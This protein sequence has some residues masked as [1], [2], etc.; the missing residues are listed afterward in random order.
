VP[1]LGDNLKLLH[2]F[3]NLFTGPRVRLAGFIL[4]FLGSLPL[5]TLN[6]PVPFFYIMCLL[7]S[8]LSTYSPRAFGWLSNFADPQFWPTFVALG[9]CILLAAHVGGLF[10]ILA[11]IGPLTA[12]DGMYFEQNY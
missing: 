4:T 9:I 12:Y 2:S 5:M 10:G 8:L 3:L 6:S 1:N 11:C 7:V